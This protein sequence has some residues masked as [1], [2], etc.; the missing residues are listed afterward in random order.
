MN[1]ILSYHDILL[2]I[3]KYKIKIIKNPICATIKK[4][5]NLILNSSISLWGTLAK[6]VRLRLEFEQLFY[7]AFH[8]IALDH[9]S[10]PTMSHINQNDWGMLS[11]ENHSINLLL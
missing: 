10:H 9:L 1:T 5:D 8:S 2:K 7:S 3:F 6:Q 4:K 11:N